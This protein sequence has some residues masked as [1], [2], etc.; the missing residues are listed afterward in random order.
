MLALTLV[1]AALF[2]GGLALWLQQAQRGDQS[3]PYS[4]TRAEDDGAKKLYL[5]LEELGHRPQRWESD[6]M[7]LERPGMMLIL[8]P[9][10][11]G[12]KRS[13]DIM[14]YEIQALD[15]WVRQGN[16]AVLFS[17][18]QNVF[19]EH[20]GL[21]ASEVDDKGLVTEPKGGEPEPAK[22]P[23]ATSVPVQPTVLA[24]GVNTLG[25]SAPGG[26]RFGVQRR[27]V[28]N[29]F[30]IPDDEDDAPPP[31]APVP[32]GEWVTLFREHVAR[33]KGA[34]S[35]VTAARGSGL[36]VAVSDPFPV[37]NAGLEHANNLEFAVNLLKLRPEGGAIWFDEF[38]HRDVA[39]GLA[40][41]VRARAL[42]PFALYFLLL[43][44]VLIWRSMVRFGPAL[45]LVADARR[46]SS[47]YVRAVATL[48]QNSGMGQEALRVAYAEFRR[49]LGAALRLGVVWDIETAARTLEQRAGVPY[50]DT[51]QAIA[52][53]ETAL[54]AGSVSD[55]DACELCGRL[56]QLE[57][58]AAG[59]WAGK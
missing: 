17:N 33:G 11:A 51:A 59:Q 16:V 34:P 41:Y 45:P 50:Q 30:G 23:T 55:E 47:E 58:R 46:D 7:L 42:S 36:Y 2:A 31:V 20:L 1:I 4:T 44:L 22:A 12:G 49:R 39:R 53:V 38:H 54:R 19:Y 25:L 10:F 26:L 32:E 21:I 29:P 27:K 52:E 8:D 14:P 56:R 13:R 24:R 40:N 48:Y 18:R 3:P 57:E 28:K 43:V 37:S 9:A 5:L 15:E 35:V 6:F